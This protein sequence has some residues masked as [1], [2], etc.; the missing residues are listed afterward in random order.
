MEKKLVKKGEFK[1]KKDYDIAYDFATNVYKH[2]RE[3][4]KSII[5]FGSTAK[6]TAQEKSDIDIIIIVDDC[7]IK[8]DQELIAW[9]REELG[10]ILAGSSYSKKLHI[11]TVTLSA[12]WNQV[13][14]GDPVVINILRFG[15]PILDFG[16]FFRSKDVVFI[17]TK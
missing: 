10:K 9:Y 4:I 3:I 15:E 8:W 11:N 14:I 12:F 7:T 16:G 13:L 6:D 2:L 5:L 17:S 1:H